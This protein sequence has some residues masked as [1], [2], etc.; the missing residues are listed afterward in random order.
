MLSFLTQECEAKPDLKI[1]E[2]LP[3]VLAAIGTAVKRIAQAVRRAGIADL[4][5]F[6]ADQD[7]A[8]RE[9][10]GGEKQK[11]LDVVAVSYVCMLYRS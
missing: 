4:T 2:E 11:K 9:N 5:G 7:G 3:L 8:S 1:D 10:Q 6:Y